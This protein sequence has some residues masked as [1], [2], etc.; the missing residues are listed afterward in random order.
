MLLLAALTTAACDALLGMSTVTFVDGDARTVPGD[1]TGESNADGSP[2]VACGE[3]GA[4]AVGV[5]ACC[6][7]QDYQTSACVV[8]GN[9][10][11]S[12]RPMFCD[13]GTACSD[14]GKPGYA[15]CATIENLQIIGSSCVAYCDMDS[16][17]VLCDPVA[18]V[19]QCA[20]LDAG[21]NCTFFSGFPGPYFACQP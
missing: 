20:A 4:C 5:E 8:P 16:A 7:A 15:C 14:M 10:S 3:A 13:N 11:A 12:S 1:A 17:V 19:D 21:L 6:W 2:G 9:C 18:A